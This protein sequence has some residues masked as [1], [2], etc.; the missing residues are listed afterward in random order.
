MAGTGTWRKFSNKYTQTTNPVLRSSCILFRLKAAKVCSM[1][2]CFCCS[3]RCSNLKF[4]R[5]VRV[6]TTQRLTIWVRFSTQNRSPAA[7][8][9]YVWK[10]VRASRN[11][12]MS[13]RLPLH[14]RLQMIF[15][16]ISGASYPNDTFKR[17]IH[18][19]CKVI[20]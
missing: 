11:Y 7:P 18:E 9:I 16:Q 10:N 5:K 3:R 4:S 14:P 8:L 6:S 12:S 1:S 2:N 15:L 20:S 13:P 19:I 17:V